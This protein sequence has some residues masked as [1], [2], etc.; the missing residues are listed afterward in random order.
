MMRR[1]VFTRSQRQILRLM[2]AG[3]RNREIAAELRIRPGSVE[4]CCARM[5]RRVEARSN[6]H[7]V[8]IAHQRGELG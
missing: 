7:L 3:K 1:S 4:E 5:R 8:A 2:V 6:V